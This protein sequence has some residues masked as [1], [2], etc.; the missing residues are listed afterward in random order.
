M[1]LRLDY[2]NQA[3]SFTKVFSPESVALFG[4]SC[5]QTSWWIRS[6]SLDRP[7]LSLNVA[8]AEGWKP[9]VTKSF[10]V[11]LPVRSKVSMVLVL[12]ESHH[13]FGWA[14]IHLMELDELPG[15]AERIFNLILLHRT[16]WSWLFCPD[17]V[18]LCILCSGLTVRTSVS[19]TGRS[20][21]EPV[22]TV[23][24]NLRSQTDLR[25]TGA[26]LWP[27]LG[28]DQNTKS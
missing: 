2:W 11:P 13:G 26:G 27:G 18:F 16:K 24:G 22:G 28:R 8:T 4:P 7:G 23:C 3:N 15:P 17:L 25:M 14:S 12:S 20:R 10:R 6:G 9:T 1:R 19:H 5:P 21:T